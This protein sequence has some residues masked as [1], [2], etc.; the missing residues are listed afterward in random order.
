[1]PLFEIYEDPEKGFSVRRGRLAEEDMTAVARAGKRR[2]R[3]RERK[4]E[5]V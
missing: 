2:E 3:E 4:K 1:M 5:R